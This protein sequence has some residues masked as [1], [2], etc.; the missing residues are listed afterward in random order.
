MDKTD[1]KSRFL[2]RERDFQANERT[3]LAWVRTAL[4]VMALGVAVAQFG[5]TSPFTTGA[6]IVLVTAGTLGLV[7][8]MRRYHRVT[9]GLR[10]GQY[11]VGA[12]GRAPEVA[13]VVLVAAILTALALI[14]AATI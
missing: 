9:R 7:Y 5:V 6:A 2:A 14:T 12:H 10:E 11:A 4:S 1:N 13:A 8:G 3:F